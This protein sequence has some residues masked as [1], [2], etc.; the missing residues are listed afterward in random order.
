[1]HRYRR[2]VRDWLIGIKSIDPPEDNVIGLGFLVLVPSRSGD[3]QIAKE[4]DTVDVVGVQFLGEE[5]RVVYGDGLVSSRAVRF[6]LLKSGYRP[7][8]DSGILAT[9]QQPSSVRV[10]VEGHDRPFVAFASEESHAR[11]LLVCWVQIP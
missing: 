5:M 7:E 6:E 9:R 1:M 8:T 3:D 4:R 11:L 10:K 2:L